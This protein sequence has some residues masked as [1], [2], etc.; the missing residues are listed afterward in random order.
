MLDNATHHQDSEEEKEQK[1]ASG[2]ESIGIAN[3]T[4]ENSLS[5]STEAAEAEAT[6]VSPQ[7]T[8]IIEKKKQS[9]LWSFVRS[10]FRGPSPTL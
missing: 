10:L 5:A 9:G 4:R 3:N 6:I 8:D 7:Q 1:M 2:V